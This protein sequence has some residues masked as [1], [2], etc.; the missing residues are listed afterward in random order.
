M[1]FNFLST[2]NIGKQELQFMAPY[3][4]MLGFQLVSC[5][6]YALEDVVPQVN[7]THKNSNYLHESWTFS[8]HWT[9]QTVTTRLVDPPARPLEIYVHVNLV[10]VE[11]PVVLILLGWHLCFRHHAVCHWCPGKNQLKSCQGI[12]TVQNLV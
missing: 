9:L 5:G 4:I 2:I 1:L 10:V 8:H 3:T 12:M 11:M 7:V 6:E